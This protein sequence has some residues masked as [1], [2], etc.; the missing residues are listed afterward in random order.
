[1][2][3]EKLWRTLNVGTFHGYYGRIGTG[4]ESGGLRSVQQIPRESCWQSISIYPLYSDN[5]IIS[6]LKVSLNQCCQ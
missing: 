4:N 5:S 6:Q 2:K 3:K 1:M